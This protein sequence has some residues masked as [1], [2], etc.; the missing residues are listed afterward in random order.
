[1]AQIASLFTLF[2]HHA[3][4]P[5]DLIYSLRNSLLKCE[6]FNNERI[7]EQQVVS[8]LDF[9]I[10]LARDYEG[11]RYVER[12]TEIVKL[13]DNPISRD[14]IDKSNLDERS[15]SFMKTTYDY[16]NK[17]VES[18]LFEARNIVEYRDGEYVFVNSISNERKEKMKKAMH[19]E[20]AMKFE[21]LMK[22]CL[23]SNEA[24]KEAAS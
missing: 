14:F 2:T 21:T 1:M 6:M 7:A 18:R 23:D 3:K 9:D 17:Q 16:Y 13:P 20:D 5:K 22:S 24:L 10:H 11:K 12:I 4:T 15:S 19:P 8:V